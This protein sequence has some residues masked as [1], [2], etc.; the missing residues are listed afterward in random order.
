MYPFKGVGEEDYPEP[1]SEYEELF[2]GDRLLLEEQALKSL[3][4]L[5]KQAVVECRAED[6]IALGE[7]CRTLATACNI[8]SAWNEA[9]ETCISVRGV[10]ND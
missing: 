1:P 3:K 9:L 10:K 2:R 8:L 6:L 4:F 7:H 5:W